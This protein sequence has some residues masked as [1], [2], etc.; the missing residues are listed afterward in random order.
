MDNNLLLLMKEYLP[1]WVISG[2]ILILIILFL[3]KKFREAFVNIPIFKIFKRKKITA[4][5]LVNHQ[6]FVFID[7]MEKYKID[8]MEF[9]DPG[10]TKIFRDY[11][12]IRCR[13][14]HTSTKHLIGEEILDL[15]P[16]EIKVKIFET[17]YSSISE[18][19]KL[20]L[21]QCSN[22]EERFIVNF[23]VEKFAAHA[24]SSIEAFKEVIETIFDSGY[25]SS[26]NFE[27]LNSMLNIFLFVFVS[28]FAE[29]EKVLHKVNGNVSGKHYKGLTL[30]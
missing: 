12:K 5:D 25:E 6:F 16:A 7:Y 28:T 1:T 3:F 24:D 10:R 11:F 13:T 21:D 15:N 29:S 8:R 19:N 20:M 18:S 4:Q 17:L 23:I 30:A 9:G 14:F 22:D 26:N 27:R 2:S